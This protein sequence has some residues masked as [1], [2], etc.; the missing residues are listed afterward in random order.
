MR[1]YEIE[2]DSLASEQLAQGELKFRLEG[3]KLQ[4]GFA[5]IR[6]GQGWLW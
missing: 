5:L 6:S 4:G 2:G 3:E 1:S